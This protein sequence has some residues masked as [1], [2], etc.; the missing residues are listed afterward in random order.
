[1]GTCKEVVRFKNGTLGPSDEISARKKRPDES[2]G[3]V[4]PSC[5][6][7]RTETKTEAAPVLR[8]ANAGFGHEPPHDMY[9]ELHKSQNSW[10]EKNQRF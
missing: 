9:I 6:R 5:G 3:T 1:M 2:V 8:M 7:M 10:M 4:G